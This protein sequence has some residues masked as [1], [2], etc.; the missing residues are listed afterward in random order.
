[1][2]RLYDTTLRDGEQMPGLAFSA[3]EKVAIATLSATLG[4]AIL[5][6][7]FP[8]A[9]PAEV[10]ALGAIL[11]ARDRGTIPRQ[12]EILTMARS[13][14]DDIQAVVEASRT[15][16]QSPADLS[17]LVFTSASRR[18]YAAKAGRTRGTHADGERDSFEEAIRF[19]LD[20]GFALVEFGAED[21]SRTPF[22]V[23]IRLVDRA[24]DAGASRYIYADTVGAL[25]PESAHAIAKDL[26]SRYGGARLV[27]HFH[28]D[29]GLAVA[30]ALAAARAG[31]QT[32]SVTFSGIGERA[33]NVPLHSF[34]V[35]LRDLHNITIDGFAYHSLTKT[36]RAVA[37]LGSLPLLPNEPVIG[38]NAFAHESGIHVHGTLAD[39]TLYEAINSATIGAS[40]SVVLG[41]HSGRSAVRHV[42]DIIE[43][44]SKLTDTDLDQVLTALKAGNE[45]CSWRRAAQRAAYEAL[46]NW[47]HTIHD[48]NGA[49]AQLR[50]SAAPD[51]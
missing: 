18:H 9:S 48:N 15:I 26:V 49:L 1:M 7:G 44:G 22:D 19:A 8:A 51:V 13:R 27:S 43:P 14:I 41:K 34:V 11:Q 16:G 31:I 45:V 29:Y 12:T 10:A 33:G 2:Q 40:Q 46:C 32:H 5:D 37:E 39:A 3:E 28:N 6:V 42:L 24:F 17:I 38:R 25:A 21:A 35:A 4:C 50:R 30:N 23:L 20:S 47:V 36:C